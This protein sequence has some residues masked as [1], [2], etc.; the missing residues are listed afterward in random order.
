MNTNPLEFNAQLYSLK[1]NLRR[2]AMSFTRNDDDADDLVQDTM[3]KA[4]RY[5]SRFETGTNLKSW[6]F[7]ILK[8]TFINNYRRK[9]KFNV[10][11]SENSI[12]VADN[13]PDNS[14]Y[15]LGESKCILDDIHKVLAKLPHDYQY[16]FI[17]YFEGYKYHEIARE[18]DIPI[19]TVKT[20]IHLAR[21]ILKKNLKAYKTR[22]RN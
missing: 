14:S 20:R 17:K 4:I 15:N 11:M 18:L 16:P 21:A 6:L 22:L 13:I 12:D 7:M 10:F 2:F 8:N 5:S 19:G 3:L 9:H 1:D